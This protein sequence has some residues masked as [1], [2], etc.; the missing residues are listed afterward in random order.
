MSSEPRLL[1]APLRGVTIRA[2]RR[3]FAREL[4]ASGFDEAVTPFVAANPGFDPL[5]DRELRPGLEPEPLPVVP[6]LIGRDP[7]ALKASVG[8]LRDAG[9][10]FVDLNCGCPYPMIRRKGRGS[11]LLRSGEKLRRMLDAGCSVLGDGAFSVKTRLGV[12]RP[13]ELLSLM[14]VFNDFPLRRIVIHA[15]TA[16][17][18]YGGVCDR[19]AFEA[20]RAVAKLP[21]V[22]NGDVP[23]PPPA[24]PVPLMVGRAFVRALGER[25]DIGVLLGRYVEASRAELSGAAPVLGRMK[26]LCA[27]WRDSPR[28]R[29]RW[30]IIKI[31]RSL[32][33]LHEALRA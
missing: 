33:E 6:Q 2:F 13:D 30:P 20:V 10:R 32:E 18:M 1:L 7:V 4:V 3:V 28:W 31:C 25:D 12:E 15:R 5:K 16:K 21:V 29:R 22:Y 14:E 17:Q 8:R 26:E 27:Y 9:Y 11:G 23:L 24:S 19:A